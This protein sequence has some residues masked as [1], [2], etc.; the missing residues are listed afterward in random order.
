MAIGGGAGGSAAVASPAAATA[1][2]TGMSRF[3]TG[4]PRK[5]RESLSRGSPKH[6]TGNLVDSCRPSRGARNGGFEERPAAGDPRRPGPEDP[7]GGCDARLGDLP[8][9]SAAVAGRPG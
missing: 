8:A 4:P 5:L 3:F 2:T 7:V 9:D 1:R 6:S